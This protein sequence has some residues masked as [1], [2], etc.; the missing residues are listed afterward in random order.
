VDDIKMGCK[1][2]GWEGFDWVNL[3]QDRYRS[4]AVVNTVMNLQF[5]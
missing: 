3:S 1:E 2:M 5:P 4:Q